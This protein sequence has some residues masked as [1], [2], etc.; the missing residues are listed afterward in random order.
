MFEQATTRTKRNALTDWVLRA[1]IA[2]AFLLFGWDKFPSAP[3]AEW[4]RF[5]ARSAGDSG[6]VT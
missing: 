3:D 2:L 1:G 6:F 5:F 4:V